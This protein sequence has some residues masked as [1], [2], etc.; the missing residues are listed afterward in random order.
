MAESGAIYLSIE[1]EEFEDTLDYVMKWVERRIKKVYQ[2]GGGRNWKE[3]REG[4][5]Y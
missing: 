5:L 2:R 4:I 1:K 3:S